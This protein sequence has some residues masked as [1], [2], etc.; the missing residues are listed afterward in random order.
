MA[1]T[2][3]C[4][5]VGVVRNADMATTSHHTVLGRTPDAD[6]ATTSHYTVL[7][8][9]PDASPAEI[10]RNYHQASLNLTDERDDG[11]VAFH[12]IAEAY[13][14]LRDPVL[15]SRYD[16]AQKKQEQEKCRDPLR[17]AHTQMAHTGSL[18]RE[19]ANLS[20]SFAQRKVELD[21]AARQTVT[22]AARQA[23]QSR[24][25]SGLA[26]YY[27]TTGSGTVYHLTPTCPRLRQ[28]AV[29]TV[30]RTGG[31]RLCEACEKASA[32][33]PLIVLSPTNANVCQTVA[34]TRATTKR[35]TQLSDSVRRPESR[36]ASH[37]VV[38]V[39]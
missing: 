7:G 12:V 4:T 36:E 13:K 27:V 18:R 11:G 16:S 22:E 26:R 33:Q 23:Q 29:S 32:K 38:D 3:H 15:R 1:P 19:V 8:V 28:T 35:H 24:P 17:R 30:A 37:E 34:T 9:A 31:R 6:M 5:V 20:R 21:E 25:S 2:S 10:R 14:T 39:R